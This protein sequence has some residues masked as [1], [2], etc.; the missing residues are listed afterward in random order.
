MWEK[1]AVPGRPQMTIWHMGFYTGYLRLQTHSEYVIFIALPLQQLDTC[2]YELIYS[3]QSILPP[4]K[5]F[6]IPPETPCIYNYV[7]FKN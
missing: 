7:C 6:T 4:P 2:L 3:E 5:I 1:I